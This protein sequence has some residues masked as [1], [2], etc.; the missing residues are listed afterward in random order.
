MVL[1]GIIIWVIKSKNENYVNRRKTKDTL[2]VRKND[3]VA[4]NRRI[5]V[6]WRFP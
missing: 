5:R 6:S 3:Y 1:G 4:S 2:E